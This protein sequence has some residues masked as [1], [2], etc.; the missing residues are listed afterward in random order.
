MNKDIERLKNKFSIT[1][2]DNE[3]VRQAG[4]MLID[5]LPEFITKWYEWLNEQEEFSLF[6]GSNSNNLKRIREQ[7]MIHWQSFFTAHIDDQYIKERRHIGEV[8]PMIFILQACQWLPNYYLMN[9]GTSNLCQLI[10][11][12]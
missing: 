6:F 2:T 9:S 12:I 3:L 1:A 4:T 10:S 11:V 8:Y 5:F 7:Q